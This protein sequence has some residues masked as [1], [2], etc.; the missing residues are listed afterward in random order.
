[1]PG[2]RTGGW[3]GPQS[4]SGHYGDEKNLLP[5]T[6]NVQFL[7]CLALSLVITL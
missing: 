3:V 6:G 2:K 4:W 7:S 5:L 1:M